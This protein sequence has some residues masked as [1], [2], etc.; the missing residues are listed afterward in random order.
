MKYIVLVLGITLLVYGVVEASIV[1]DS[2]L[3][4]RIFPKKHGNEQA[5]KK[6]NWTFFFHVGVNGIV[7]GLILLYIA[8]LLF[9]K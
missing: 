5:R 6:W 2:P 3:F 4:R 8:Y 9:T 7:L 1:K